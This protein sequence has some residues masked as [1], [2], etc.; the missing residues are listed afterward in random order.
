[1]LGS[2]DGGKTVVK[3]DLKCEKLAKEI[4]GQLNLKLHDVG[5]TQKSEKLWLA[6][7]VELHKGRDGRYWI[8]DVARLFPPFP[9]TSKELRHLILCNF[10]RPVVVKSNSVPLSADAF[11]G[12]NKKSSSKEDND[13]VRACCDQF[14]NQDIPNCAKFWDNTPSC[15]FSEIREKFGGRV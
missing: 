5:T 4:A 3:R 15:S 10:L 11:S 8:V 7:D 9:P 13:E 12:F 6:G 14:L 1:M 2:E